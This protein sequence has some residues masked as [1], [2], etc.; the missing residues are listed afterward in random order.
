M[1]VL[2]V[3]G[4]YSVVGVYRCFRVLALMMEA[5]STSELSVNFYQAATAQ[6]ITNFI[7]TTV[8]ISDIKC[9]IDLVCFILTKNNRSIDKL[10]IFLNLFNDGVSASCIHKMAG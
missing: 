9:H 5:A 8:K 10:H 2:W 6:N 1:A 3:V 4:L 7:L